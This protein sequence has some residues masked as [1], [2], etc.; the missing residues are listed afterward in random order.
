MTMNESTF[1]A[2]IDYA[3]RMVRTG[4]ASVEQA[5]RTCGI[6]VAL[7]K[8]RLG[9]GTPPNSVAQPNTRSKVAP[10]SSV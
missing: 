3:L 8:A 5:A 2:D 7:L 1:D 9:G 10:K 6:P 4:C